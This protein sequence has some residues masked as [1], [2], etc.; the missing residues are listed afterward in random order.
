MRMSSPPGQGCGG[1]QRGSFPQ[2]WEEQTGACSGQEPWASFR[3]NDF[4][5][6]QPLLSPEE[7]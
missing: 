7:Y 3:E 5:E 2:Q 1:P 6:A 4:R